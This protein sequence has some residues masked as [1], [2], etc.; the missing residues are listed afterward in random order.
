MLGE[1]VRR[2]RR[3][4]GLTQQQLADFAGISRVTLS[5]LEAGRA[6]DIGVRKVIKLLD[7]LGYDLRLR[8]KSRFP[9]FEELRD[10]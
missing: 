6:S 10:A 7:L 5:G 4:A 1:E 9:T 2:L 3:E 8:E